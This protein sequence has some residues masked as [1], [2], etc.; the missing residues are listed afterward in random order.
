V[1]PVV[2][3]NLSTEIR[4][5]VPNADG[6]VSTVRTMSIGTDQGEVLIPTVINGRVVSDD[7]AIRHFEQT[8]ENFG[9]FR[10]P[11]EATAY[12]NALHD[13]HARQLAPS[14][15][16]GTLDQITMMAESGGNPNAVSPKGARG[17]MQVMPATA[18]DPGF[19]IRPS[20]GTPQDDVRVGREYRA[21]MERRYGGDL[22]KMWGAYNWG[23]GNLDRALERYGEDWLRYAPAETR[24][25]VQNN[26]RQVRG[27]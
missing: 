19:G 8:G 21:A 3:G 6:S 14:P 27:R 25:Y 12:A 16:A 2:P 1:Q 13:Y 10:T 15:A 11:D 4:Y 17:L 7:E 18:R 24:N 26:L 9:T 5:R 22:A 20:D 23:P